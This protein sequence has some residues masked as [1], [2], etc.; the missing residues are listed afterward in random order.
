MGRDP[1]FGNHWVRYHFPLSFNFSSSAFGNIRFPSNFLV[2]TQFIAI[3]RRLC[4]CYDHVEF[5]FTVFKI[6]A[7]QKSETSSQTLLSSF[8]FGKSYSSNFFYT[9]FISTAF[10]PGLLI[11]TLQMN[12]TFINF[13]SR[14]I[15]RERNAILRDN[16]I[17]LFLTSK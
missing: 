4:W 1:Q 12:N 13:C 11:H 9:V 8:E 10:L 2:H 16:Q 7:P 5:I 14:N 15:S 6:Y 3:Y 17:T